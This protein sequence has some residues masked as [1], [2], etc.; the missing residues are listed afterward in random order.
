ML[1][2]HPSLRDAYL[3]DGWTALTIAAR[4]GNVGMVNLLIDQGSDVNQL[5][6]GGNSALFWAV[7]YGHEEVV[8]ILL[9]RQA[10]IDNKCRECRDPVEIARE[11]NFDGILKLLDEYKHMK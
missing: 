3:N 1:S 7:Y 11:K 6:G 9:R 10:R 5:E 8:S 2:E 4:E